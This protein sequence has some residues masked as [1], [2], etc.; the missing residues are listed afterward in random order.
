ME[1]YYLDESGDASAKGSK[2]LILTLA[3]FSQPKKIRKTIQRTREQ[4][5]RKTRSRKWLDQ[6]GGE[7]KFCGFPDERLLLEALT[8][9][10]E[11]NTTVLFVAFDKGGISIQKS[12]KGTIIPYL[13]QFLVN[14]KMKIPKKVTADLDFLGKKSIFFG[15]SKYQ[16]KRHLAENGE[17]RS[18]SHMEVVELTPEDF[19]KSVNKMPI[20]ELIHSNSRGSPELQAVDLISG[21]LFQ[22]FENSK[23]KYLDVLKKGKIKISGITYSKKK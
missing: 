7:V 22:K 11:M 1:F 16:T 8:R 10:A 13:F 3:V 19:K 4:L 2:Y 9:L 6:H 17:E 15:L 18:E 12:T 23:G 14:S 20:I 5:L 21:A